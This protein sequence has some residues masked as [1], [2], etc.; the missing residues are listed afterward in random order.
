MLSVAG[1]GRFAAGKRAGAG[2]TVKYHT[3]KAVSN[4]VL[5]S[6]LAAVT[7]FLKAGFHKNDTPAKNV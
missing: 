7:V 5:V 4:S 6:Q 3:T 2:Q 1:I